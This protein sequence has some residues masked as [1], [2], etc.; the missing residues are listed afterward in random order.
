MK[1]IIWALDWKLF[2]WMRSL[3]LFSVC[4]VYCA[5]NASR[6]R[7]RS[8]LA[9]VMNSHRQ[10]QVCVWEWELHNTVQTFV[11]YVYCV[12]FCFCWFSLVFLNLFA[13]ISV[14][15][16]LPRFDVCRFA[17]VA[18]GLLQVIGAYAGVQLHRSA[19]F[20]IMRFDT[21]T[22]QIVYGIVRYVWWLRET[23][24][25]RQLN[26]SHFDEETVKSNTFR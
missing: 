10:I 7:Y 3:T 13:R 6:Y 25:K 24:R 22:E 23:E 20:V 5:A 18:F 17:T 16:Y 1:R 14:S 9:S 2:A 4:F 11:D 12:Y 21:D 19:C 15:F 26:A 8:I